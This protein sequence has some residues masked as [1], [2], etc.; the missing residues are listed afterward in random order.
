ML[1]LEKFGVDTKVIADLNTDLLR[2]YIS[3]TQKLMKAW[4]G[5]IHEADVKLT[6][7]IDIMPY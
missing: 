4:M 6:E 7:A 5:R 2:Q 1:T 3:V